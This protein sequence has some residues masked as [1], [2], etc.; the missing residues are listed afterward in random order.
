[1]SSSGISPG[2]RTSVWKG[3]VEYWTRILQWHR[4]PKTPSHCHRLK[5]NLHMIDDSKS[6]QTFYLKSL[7][8]TLFTYGNS[9][10]TECDIDPQGIWFKEQQLLL[11]RH[12]LLCL[13]GSTRG[14][15]GALPAEVH[16]WPIPPDS[17]AMASTFL[18]TQPEGGRGPTGSYLR[19]V[20]ILIWQMTKPLFA[21]TPLH[22][23][24]FLSCVL[25]ERTIF[26]WNTQ[27][28]T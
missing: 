21:K 3:K 11:R 19:C 12:H 6:R 8:A 1:M 24:K 18:P 22:E 27:E 9:C 10:S 28:Y 20:L 15:Y 13:F 26:T 23:L 2:Y 5:S 25:A 4:I 14:S 17:S 16:A 7:K